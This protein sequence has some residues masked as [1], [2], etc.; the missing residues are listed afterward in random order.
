M[1]KLIWICL[2]VVIVVN[3]KATAQSESIF[4]S[5]SFPGWGQFYNDQP[6]KGLIII[7]AEAALIGGSIYFGKKQT[8]K[9]ND[10]LI[11]TNPLETANLY[12]D[13]EKYR[14]LKRLSIALAGTLWIYN[15]IDAWLFYDKEKHPDY[16]PHNIGLQLDEDRLALCL[17]IDFNSG[18]GK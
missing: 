10:Y 12:D 5:I 9:Y 7:G 14:D 8:D 15:V 2:L 16:I 13:A 1:R 18:G 17:T 3:D 11:S 4:R 6:R